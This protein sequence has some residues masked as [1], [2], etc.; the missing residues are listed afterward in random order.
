MIIVSCLAGLPAA[1][2]Y[3]ILFGAC[4]WASIDRE[5]HTHLEFLLGSICAVIGFSTAWLG[6]LLL[7]VWSAFF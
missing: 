6:H 7:L 5:R 1:L 4:A 2:P 3:V